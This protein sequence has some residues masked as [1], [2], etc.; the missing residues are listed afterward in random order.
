MSPPALVWFGN[1]AAVE[2]RTVEVMPDGRERR[3]RIP[4]DGDRWTVM[5][6]LAATVAE[7]VALLL[8]P[9]GIWAAHS[10]APRPSWV[11]SDDDALAAELS[12]TLA[13]PIVDPPTG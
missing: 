9:D 7:F 11:A 3:A 8:H 1:P 2:I 5:P 6:F 12:A 13:L 4:L 10:N